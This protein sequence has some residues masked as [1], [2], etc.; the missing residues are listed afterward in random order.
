MNKYNNNISILWNCLTIVGRVSKDHPGL[1]HQFF[2]AG[3]IDCIVAVMNQH[4]D[5]VHL[6]F[7]CL[8]AIEVFTYDEYDGSKQLVGTDDNIGF[9][10]IVHT[11]K[12]FPQNSAIQR[13]GCQIIYNV[14]YDDLLVEQIIDAGAIGVLAAAMERPDGF[15]S[16]SPS[17]KDLARTAMACLL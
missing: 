4:A 14:S 12:T 1:V 6:Q 13:L 3:I 5:D 2:Y 17:I 16:S 7:V 8:S 10:A 9:E 11:M 15:A